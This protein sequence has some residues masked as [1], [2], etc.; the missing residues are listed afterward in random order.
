MLSKSGT[1]TSMITRSLTFLSL[2]LSLSFYVLKMRTPQRHPI[3]QSK[4]LDRLPSEPAVERTRS[5]K[6]AVRLNS[7]N[8]LAAHKLDNAK[9]TSKATLAF[10]FWCDH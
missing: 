4:I 2:S 6:L 10:P 7:I 3:Q 9:S 8:I 5:F 1:L